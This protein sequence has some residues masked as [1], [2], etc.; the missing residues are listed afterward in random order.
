METSLEIITSDTE[1]YFNSENIDIGNAVKELTAHMRNKEYYPA[2]GI[3]VYSGVKIDNDFSTKNLREIVCKNHARFENA[4]LKDAGM[5]GSIFVETDFGCC[6]YTNTNFQSSDFRTCTFS[7]AHLIFTAFNRSC[8]VNTAFEDCIFDSVSM[9]DCKFINCRFIRCKWGVRVENTIFENC[10]LIDVTF[11]N[12]NLEFASFE[13]LHTENV[14]L[15]FPTIPYIYGGL[16]YLINTSDN[17]RISSAT[18]KSGISKDEYLN[19]LDYLEQYYKGTQNYF[20]LCNILIAKKQY[21]YALICVVK[22]LKNAILIRKFRM[23]INYCKLLRHIPTATAHIRQEIYTELMNTLHSTQLA[24]FEQ[25]SL[26]FYLPQAISI[27]FNDLSSECLVVRFD[28]NIMNSDTQRLGVFYSLIDRLL[29]LNC[30]YSVEIRHNSPISVLLQ[31]VTDPIYLSI[32]V[33]TISMAFCGIQLSYAIRDFKSKKDSKKNNESVDTSTNHIANELIV[34]EL[35]DEDKKLEE[36]QR[37]ESVRQDLVIQG[38]VINNC[39]IYIN[40]NVFIQPK[41]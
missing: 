15:P 27:L 39:T 22:G 24:S 37:A 1:L 31:I 18:K 38:I 23:L 32:I 17:V 26:D 7:G 9:C 25:N 5:A 21:K 20:P 16:T 30:N 3:R 2:E 13:N 41:K 8:F 6:D 12:M 28:T 4:N 40:G 19:C 36:Q 29:G 35:I 33:S 14:K 11:R 34:E 10:E